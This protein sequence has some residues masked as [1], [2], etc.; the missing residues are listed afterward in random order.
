MR[1]DPPITLRGALKILGRDDHPWLTRINSLLGGV[2]LVSGPLSLVGAAFGAIWQMVDQKSEANTR[3]REVLDTIGGRLMGTSGL[4]RQDLVVAAHSTIV[5]AAYSTAVTKHIDVQLS[6]EQKALIADLRRAEGQKLVEALYT[7]EIPTPSAVASFEANLAALE[8][9]AKL[10]GFVVFDVFGLPGDWTTINRRI[11]DDFADQYRSYFLTLAAQVP[12]FKVWADQVAQENVAR[13]LAAITDLL[14]HG[15]TADPR[16]HRS[17]VAMANRAELDKPI[18]DAA[19]SLVRFPPVSD[20][21]LTP[22]YRLTLSG[23]EG[24]I[25]NEKWWQLRPVHHDL[26]VMLA[27]HFGTPTALTRP[28]LLLGHPGAGKSVLMTALAAMLPAS[29]YTVVRVRLRHVDAGASVAGQVAQA[30]ELATNN[31]VAWSDLDGSGD[32][33]RVV[34][35]DGLDEL[36]QATTADRT[37]YLRDVE[38]FQRTEAVMGQPVAVVV[39]SRTLVADRVT[40]QPGT[41]VVKI[42]EFDEGQIKAWLSVW[43]RTN[44]DTRSLPV[45]NALALPELASQPLL[46]MMLAIYCANP[47]VPLPDENMSLSD[48][49]D[50]LL[51]S[52]AEREIEKSADSVDKLLWRL[53]IAAIGMLNRG[54]QYLSEADLTADLA[55]LGD[56]SLSG[57]QVLSQFFFIHAS[58]A[59]TARGSVRGYEFLHA[60]FGE[61]LVASRVVEVLRDVA[62]SSHGRR[63]VHEPDDDLL[64]AL[65]SHQPL[66]TQRPT[67]EF[68]GEQLRLLDADERESVER[69]LDHLLRTFRRRNPV[70]RYPTYL[71]DASDQVTGL[72]T[73]SAN[74]VL[75][76][77]H[78]AA[79]FDHEKLWPDDGWEAVLRLWTAGLDQQGL[80]AVVRCLVRRGDRLEPAGPTPARTALLVAGLSDDTWTAERIRLGTVFLDDVPRSGNR[81]A[82][83]MLA[84]ALVRM[85]MPELR[86]S[87]SDVVAELIELQRPDQVS[88]PDGDFGVDVEWPGR[89]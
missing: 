89:A 30:L 55:A 4:H 11:I 52:F 51:A 10:V 38:Q 86:I 34:L 65:M 6:D 88:S 32:T 85:L 73:Y 47:D 21:F 26:A 61:Y 8:D 69:T 58:E 49:Y 62:D 17:L 74:L 43:N 29:D 33:V 67:I 35:L 81:R 2:V 31:R 46:L 77:L 82:P 25:S 76:R 28:L 50:K 36:L 7:A 37:G 22:R 66:A 59:T 44:V 23:G 16:D 79:G 63:A 15:P 78:L 84:H 3:I 42:E 20:V 83:K 56:K 53:S 40:V 87:P 54:A 68:I 12:D 14:G 60:T 24:R 1:R 9:W 72:A 75:L 19:D 27:R 39:T 41:P 13:G 5:L 71:P 45:A 48:L 18:V 80:S 64:F 57:G 70:N